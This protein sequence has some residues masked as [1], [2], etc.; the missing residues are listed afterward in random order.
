MHNFWSLNATQTPVPKVMVFLF[1]TVISLTECNT[2][3]AQKLLS[4]VSTTIELKK[5]INSIRQHWHTSQPEHTPLDAT[6]IGYS[7]YI[8]ELNCNI[9]SKW[10]VFGLCHCCIRWAILYLYVKLHGSHRSQRYRDGF[11][12]KCTWNL[13]FGTLESDIKT[14]S[15][16]TNRS[17]CNSRNGTCL[18]NR[19]RF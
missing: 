10:A 5:Y 12:R 18:N 13:I 11:L 9:N 19:W 7:C 8:F 6:T 16:R 3:T 14:S 2:G 1:Q 4:G 17:L 15:Y